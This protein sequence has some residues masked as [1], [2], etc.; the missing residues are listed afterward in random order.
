MSEQKNIVASVKGRLLH[1]A[2]SEDKNHQLLLLRYFQERFLY[3]LSKSQYSE[4][5]CLK[6]AAFLYALEGERSRVTKDIDFL[7]VHIQ[8]THRSIRQAIAE[9]CEISHKE[10][11]V[12]F[13]LTSLEL[14]DI[15]K[16]GNYQGIRTGITAHLD[17]TKQRLQIDIGF[18]DVV[19][20]AP[21]EMT[22]PVILEMEAPIIIAYSIESTLAE[23]FEAMIALSEINT[24]MKDFYDVYHLLKNHSVNMVILEEAIR[25]T[26]ERRGTL[27]Q[28]DHSLYEDTFHLNEERNAR[29][30]AFL[31]KAKLDMGLEFST[32][33]PF[34][35]S[36][37]KP[38][39]LRLF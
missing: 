1:I 11:G 31:R 18:G 35:N 21:M 33:M 23:K 10:D 28:K 30:K 19:V 5:F 9:I 32:V 17:R 8:A 27:A 37:L 38:I 2:R 13:D 12:S 7:G 20:P 24:R 4:H 22:Y 39:Y 14:E 16:D 3:R 26:F 36:H 6:G 29:W 15:V 34:I 25:Q